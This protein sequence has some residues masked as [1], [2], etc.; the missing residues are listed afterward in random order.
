MRRRLLSFVAVAAPP[1]WAATPTLRPLPIA[2]FGTRVACV[3]YSEG[4]TTKQG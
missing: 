4:Q 2:F 3:L 1:Q